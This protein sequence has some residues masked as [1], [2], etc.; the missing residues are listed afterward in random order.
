M[1]THAPVTGTSDRPPVNRIRQLATGSV[2][3]LVEYFDWSAYSFLAIYFADQFFPGGESSAVPLLATFGVF[4]VGFL[5]RPIGGVIMGRIADRKGRRLTL[6]L[7][8]GMMGIGSLLIAVSPTYA[9]CGV[10]APIIL[11][12]ARL[13]QGFSTGG[14]LATAGAFLMESAPPNRRGVYTSLTNVSSSVGKVLCLA[15]ITALVS[16]VG[17]GAMADWAWRVPFAIGAVAAVSAWWI[18]R[19]AEETLDEEHQAAADT[20]PAFKEVFVEYRLQF[21]N[22]FVLASVTGAMFYVWTTYIP[23]WAVI[24]AGLSKGHAVTISTIAFCFYGAI[25]VPLGRL[26]DRIGRRPMIF[27]FLGLNIALTIPMF[28]LVTSDVPIMLAVQ[29]IG[30]GITAVLM[31]ASG[32]I[33]GEMFPARIR[34]LA[35]GTAVSFATAVFGGTIPAIG[36]ALHSVGHPMLFPAYLTALNLV[37]FIVI[38]RIPETAHKPLP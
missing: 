21:R 30:V 20:K 37:A 23:T 33:L 7:G 25:Q 1:P 22:A 5:T 6:T 29:C 14:E 17:P 27:A 28:L 15:I 3:H 36:T 16:L 26:S 10:L 4:A 11:V 24:T 31:A 35:T 19:R 8:V 18:R 32:A 34:V 9:Q 2:G 13:V 12:V 38:R